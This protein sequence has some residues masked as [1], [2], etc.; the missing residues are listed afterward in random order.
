VFAGRVAL[1]TG[2]ASG[3]GHALARELAR[4]G[5]R[6]VLCDIDAGR[7]ELLAHALAAGGADAIALALDVA[8]A[9]AFERVCAAAVERHG[10]IDYLFNN[11]G[12]AV[13]GDVR[14]I[15]LADWRRIVEVNLMGV[16]HGVRAAYPRFA[17]QGSGHVV[18][19]ASVAGLV[20]FAPLTPYAMTKH[21]VVGLSLSL[22]AE[23][24]A[25]GVRV[26]A[27]CPGF[28]ESGI[29][30]AARIARLEGS[31]GVRNLSLFK[32]V[33]ADVAA[34]RILAGVA[35]NRAVIVFPFYA[36]VLWWLSRIHPALLAPVGR[37]T[38]R[39]FRSMLP[40]DRGSG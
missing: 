5:A 30:D 29:Y 35:R 11:A 15:A 33:P 6:L 16:V 7:C 25:L 23:A 37:H 18:N 36:R 40:K 14:D 13:G 38:M 22:R 8:D 2:A 12:I 28:I 4:R 19:T 39:R 17:A 10:R 24:A 20:P 9:E 3:I 21:A 31:S 26:S 34:K 32:L 1:V 27:V